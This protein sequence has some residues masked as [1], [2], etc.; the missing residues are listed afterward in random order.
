MKV[1]NVT[2]AVTLFSKLLFIFENHFK[3]SS[4]KFCDYVLGLPENIREA[5]FETISM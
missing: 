2:H 4:S 3:F 5:Y 1:F